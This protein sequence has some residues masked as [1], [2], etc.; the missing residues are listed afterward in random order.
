MDRFLQT[1]KN[2]NN[3]L[4]KYTKDDD[5]RLLVVKNKKKAFQICE[6]EQ[7]IQC[8]EQ[9]D[10]FFCNTCD[11]VSNAAFRKAGVT[12]LRMKRWILVKEVCHGDSE[13]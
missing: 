3:V 12:T 4:Y 6:P 10:S 2:I 1:K 9:T 5:I 13:T 7:I 11:E 8:I